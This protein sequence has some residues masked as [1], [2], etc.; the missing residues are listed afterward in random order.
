MKNW[1][2]FTNL[3]DVAIVH[4][5]LTGDG[6]ELQSGELDTPD[7]A[8]HT[9]VVVTIPVKSYEP[10]PGVEYFLDL[11]FCLKHDTLWAKAGHEFAWDQFKLPDATPMTGTERGRAPKVT[12]NE[13]NIMV[14]GR[15]FTA[16]FD[17]KAGAFTSWKF[18]GVE[19][20][21]IPLRPDFWRALTD[22]DRGRNANKSQGIWS[23]AGEDAQLK[24]MTSET[25][26]DDSV[27][28]HATH[29]LPSVSAEWETSYIIRGSGDIVVDAHF[30]PGRTDLPKLPRLGMQ[31]A[32]PKGFERI[33][34][35]GPGPQE[36]YSDR[37]DSRLGVYSGTVD[38]QF[39]VD[40]TEPG[41]SG[42]KADVRWVAFTNNQGVGLLA[43]GLPL[44][45]VNALHYGEEDLNAGKH[46]FE[47]PR[48][49][50][51]T[52][53]LDWKQQGVGGDNSWGAWPHDEFLI[54]CAEQSYRFRL[55]PLSAGED[56]EVVARAAQF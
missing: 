48:R 15:N 42:N 16:T 5:R 40:Y 8:P 29:V 52:L 36:T 37:K 32:L 17:K 49:D 18:K 55:H 25:L 44:L 46:A 20:I 43:V 45:S 51:I 53:N 34:W 33:T 6:M 35:L 13:A 56:P 12:Q 4:W 47:L 9:A 38:E 54:P 7:L 19:L 10:K 1:F 41:E 50:F 31:M 30:K 23:K 11:S 39:Y 3:K 28:V 2:D 22:N 27:V 14:A 21:Q 26:A 24:S